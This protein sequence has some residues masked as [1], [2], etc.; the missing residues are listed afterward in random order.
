MA[1]T[2]T[3]LYVHCVFAVQNRFGLIGKNWK[4]DLYKYMAGIIEKQKHKLYVINGMPDHIHALISMNPSQ[5]TSDLIYHIKRSS[6]IWINDNKLVQ[7]KFSWQE[8]FGAFSLSKKDAYSVINYIKNQ[9]S[10]HGKKSFID[11]YKEFLIE[12]DVQFDEKYIFKA[13]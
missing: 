13:I 10:H 4:D 11:E 7:G 3:Q 8:G 9:E 12:N 5:S 6:S 2:Y 1:N